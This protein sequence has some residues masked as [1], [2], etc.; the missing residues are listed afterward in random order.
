ME[1]F[2][3]VIGVVG[4]GLALVGLLQA[5]FP[6]STPEGPTVNIKAGLPTVGDDAASLVCVRSTPHGKHAS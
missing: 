1:S 2:N 5:N 3:A 4:A 6:E